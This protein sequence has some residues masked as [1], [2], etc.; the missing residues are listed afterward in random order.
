MSTQAAPAQQPVGQE[1]ASQAQAWSWQRCPASQAA[2]EPQTQEPVVEQ[3]S[4]RAAPQ[5]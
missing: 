1:V 5:A 3:A 2:P 4:A